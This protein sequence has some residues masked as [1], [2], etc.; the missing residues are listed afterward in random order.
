MRDTFDH[1]VGHQYIRPALGFTCAYASPQ[2][3]TRSRGATPFPKSRPVVTT[4]DDAEI[5]P[6][7][8]GDAF[9][10]AVLWNSGPS[11]FRRFSVVNDV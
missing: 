11:G 3:F 4:I 2:R 7:P 6:P 8:L 1:P 9:R 10:A 5:T